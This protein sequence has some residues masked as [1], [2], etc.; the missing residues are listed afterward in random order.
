MFISSRDAKKHPGIHLL[1][2]LAVRAQTNWCR[3]FSQSDEAEPF[4]MCVLPMVCT[5]H[6]HSDANFKV[7]TAHLLADIT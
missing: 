6:L 5:T 2:F 3:H 7:D 4:T 1:P